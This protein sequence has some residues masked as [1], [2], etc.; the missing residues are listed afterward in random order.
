LKE[1]VFQ[2]ITI[3]VQVNNVFDQLF[4][5]NGYTWGYDVAGDR[6]IENF[7]YPQAGRNFMTRMTIKL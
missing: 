1:V 4:E 2:E 6:T 5:N 7:Y 3:G